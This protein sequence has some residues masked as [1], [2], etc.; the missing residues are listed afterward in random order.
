MY[1]VL[2][3]L[4]LLLKLDN[5]K[6]KQSILLNAIVNLVWFKKLFFKFNLQA[7]KRTYKFN[8]WIKTRRVAHGRNCAQPMEADNI[9]RHRN[10]NII[11]QNA[12][13]NNELN[14]TNV[15]NYTKELKKEIIE[16]TPNIR[17]QMIS[18]RK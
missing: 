10:G 5:W 17:V 2:N 16:K 18:V 12:A 7:N 3:F 8:T 14:I 1:D 9:E 4:K 11:K 13:Q 15:T 6:I